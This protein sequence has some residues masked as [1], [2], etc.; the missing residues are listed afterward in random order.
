M[1]IGNEKEKATLKSRPWPEADHPRHVVE[2][3]ILF[4]HAGLLL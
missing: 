1:K 2:D 4:V 3:V